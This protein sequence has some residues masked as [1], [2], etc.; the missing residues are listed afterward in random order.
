MSAFAGLVTFFVGLIFPLLKLGAV[1]VG[2]T[3]NVLPVLLEQDIDVL[4]AGTVR[5]RDKLLLGFPLAMISSA[6]SWFACL[7]SE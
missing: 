6:V 7:P 1:L 3:L 2:S 4:L 5:I